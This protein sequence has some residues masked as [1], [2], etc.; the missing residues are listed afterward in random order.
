MNMP[1]MHRPAALRNVVRTLDI[2][3]SHSVM[4][5]AC[6]CFEVPLLLA[7]RWR[8]RAPWQVSLGLVSGWGRGD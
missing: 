3:P 5:R 1:A 2:G 7:A 4:L 8:R 6:E